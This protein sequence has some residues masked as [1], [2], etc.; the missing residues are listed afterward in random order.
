MIVKGKSCL[1]NI[2]I[3]DYCFSL[4]Y[5]GDVAEWRAKWSVHPYG[6]WADERGP[7][8]PYFH[9]EGVFGT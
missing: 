7:R 1:R 2:A 4:A 5:V 9:P 3:P 6:R 8:H